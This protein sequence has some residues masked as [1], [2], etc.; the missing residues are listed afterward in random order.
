MYRPFVASFFEFVQAADHRC[1][2]ASRIF[3]PLTKS[4][5]MM[6]GSPKEVMNDESKIGRWYNPSTWSTVLTPAAGHRDACSPMPIAGWNSGNR[7]CE[8]KRFSFRSKD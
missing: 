4:Q 6:T 5:R 8:S 7:V 2:V 3:Q 1:A